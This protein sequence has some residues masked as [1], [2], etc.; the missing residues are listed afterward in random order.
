MKVLCTS[1]FLLAGAVLFAQSPT[2]LTKRPKT[3][4][5]N[6]FGASPIVA[7]NFD[8]RFAKT[9]GGWGASLGFG[10]IGGSGS[11]R[12]QVPVAINY[13]I[14]KKNHFVEIAAGTSW[15]NNRND[16]NRFPK[17]EAGFIS[18]ASLGYRFQMAK[19]FMGRVGWSPLHTGEKFKPSYFY[20]GIGASF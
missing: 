19:G 6:L 8:T 10:T 2:A 7:I 9:P 3:V 15:M 16:F 5:L 17:N 18:H 4:Y 11:W 20:L 12:F 1:I 14:G 13:L